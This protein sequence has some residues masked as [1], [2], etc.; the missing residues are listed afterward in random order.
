MPSAVRHDARPSPQILAT[1]RAAEHETLIAHE[2]NRAIAERRR[3]AI[4]IFAG[5][6]Q[7]IGVEWT[8]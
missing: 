1:D 5:Q 4:R 2:A 8:N 3:L 6:N 7:R